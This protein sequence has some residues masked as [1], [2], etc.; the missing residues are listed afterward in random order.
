[1]DSGVLT[2]HVPVLSY[3]MT[4]PKKLA[5]IQMALVKSLRIAVPN[6]PN[7][8]SYLVK[9]PR[10]FLTKFVILQHFRC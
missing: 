7:Q 3:A 2:Y 9:Y 8:L 5:Q 1:M 10:F 4:D 6:D